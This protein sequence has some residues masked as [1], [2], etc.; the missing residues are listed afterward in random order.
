MLLVAM[1]LLLVASLLLRVVLSHLED[2]IG[3]EFDGVS[4]LGVQ[5]KGLTPGAGP[6]AARGARRHAVREMSR[7][8]KKSIKRYLRIKISNLKHQ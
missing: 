5:E 2:L 6:A 8:K 1:P 7:Y 3:R 4:A